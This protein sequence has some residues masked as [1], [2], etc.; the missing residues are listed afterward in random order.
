MCPTRWTVRTGAIKAVLDNYVL[1]QEILEDANHTARDQ[2]GIT[3]GGVATLMEQFSTYFGFRLSH[4]LFATAEIT[5][6]PECCK[7]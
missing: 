4:H 7:G 1:L 3:A 2:N 5:S 6:T